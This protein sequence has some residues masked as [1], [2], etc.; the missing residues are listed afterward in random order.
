MATGLLYSII[1]G[2]HL[3]GEITG[4]PVILADLIL[5]ERDSHAARY[6]NGR[7]SLLTAVKPGS[8]PPTLS[9]TI[10]IDRGYTLDVI[11]LN[12]NL[13]SVQRVCQPV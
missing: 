9:S 11:V 6:L 12:I 2:T 3:L 7:L 8:C 10:G 4:E 1:A 5:N 13:Q